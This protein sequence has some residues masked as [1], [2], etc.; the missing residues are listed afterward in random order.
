ML[1][2]ILALVLKEFQVLGQ[3]RPALALLFLMPA[4]F[5]VVMSL[6]LGNVF[7]AGTVE[8]P[9]E[10][11]VVDEDG[12][13]LALRVKRE[14][15]D[16][17]GIR[18][19]TE[20]DGIPVSRTAAEALIRDRV[21]PLALILPSGLSNAGGS[22]AP[23]VPLLVDPAANQ[24]LVAPLRGAVEGVLQSLVLLERLPGEIRASLESWAAER[25]EGPVPEKV[26]D[27]L[28]KR[29]SE[30]LDDVDPRTM[31]DV[32]LRFPTGMEPPRRPTATQQAV[33]AYT[34]FGVFF[35]TLTLAT[36]FV[37]ERDDG[38]LTRLLL[39]PVSRSALLLGKLFPYYLVNLV[40][41]ALM[42]LVGKTLFDHPLGDP[43]A[44]IAV[45]LAL[46]AAAT[47][48]GALIATFA[49]TEAQVGALAVSS[50]ITLA[51][52]GGLMVPSYVM[53]GPMQTIALAIPQSWAL[54]GYHDV[55][56]RGGM[57]AD[58]LLEVSVLAGFASLFLAAAG[59]R[60]RFH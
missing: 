49:R 42:F 23:V 36:S 35:I 34:I 19:I 48:L 32:P 47:G 24:Q 37:R 6:A 18:V 31:V 10:L 33:P 57:L 52:L 44:L 40:Q 41:I 26:L 3:D 5:I 60:F 39:S 7:E 4:F 14:L 54:E 51:A 45:S 25:D 1:R 28:G 29:L 38:T 50:S 9:L 59:L 11:V 8:R 43:L 16:A 53:P 56:L 46:A 2:P 12:G 17:D 15:G 22:T 27:S 20:L 58:V 13:P 30:R 21:V 55:M